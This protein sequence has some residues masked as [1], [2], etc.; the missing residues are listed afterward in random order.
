MNVVGPPLPPP[1]PPTL[2]TL[3]ATSLLVGEFVEVEAERRPR[4]PFTEG[5]EED[6]S[7]ETYVKNMLSFKCF[8]SC[9][10]IVF[11]VFSASCSVFAAAVA[12]VVAFDATLI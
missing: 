5:A 9:C 4:R 6:I 2:A 11:I 1:P 10:Y 8:R 3:T 12:I 7:M